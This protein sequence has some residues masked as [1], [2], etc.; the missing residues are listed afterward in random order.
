[1]IEKEEKAFIKK[2]ANE[3]VVAINKQKEE[4]EQRERA[5]NAAC[6]E[7]FNRIV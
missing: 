5:R 1:M 2:I 3:V 7:K 4:E 6:Y